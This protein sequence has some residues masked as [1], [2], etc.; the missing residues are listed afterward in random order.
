MSTHSKKLDRKTNDF[1]DSIEK[2]NQLHVDQNLRSEL[3]EKLRRLARLIIDRTN[4]SS[5][6]IN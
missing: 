4:K 5:K 6:G 3:V 1:L 2:M